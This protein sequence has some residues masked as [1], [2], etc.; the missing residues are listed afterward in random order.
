MCGYGTARYK[1]K[2]CGEVF[3]GKFEC[4]FA[5][6]HCLIN[7]KYYW[8]SD[9]IILEYLCNHSILLELKNDCNICGEKKRPSWKELSVC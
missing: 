9:C 5:M 2:T 7:P 6:K 4:N 1:C 3:E 8:E